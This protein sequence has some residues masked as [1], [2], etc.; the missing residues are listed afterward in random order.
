MGTPKRIQA[1]VAFTKRC[2]TAAAGRTPMMLRSEQ[3]VPVD[4]EALVF[5]C[6]GTLVNTMPYYWSSW[7]GLIAKYNLNFSQKRFYELAGTPVRDIVEIVL[8]ESGRDIDQRWI[9]A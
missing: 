2:T 8:Q 3:R 6:D 4:I 1:A 9:D 5:D 7:E